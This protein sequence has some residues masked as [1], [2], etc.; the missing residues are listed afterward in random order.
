[1]EWSVF[2]YFI[3]F[4]YYFLF[5]SFIIIIIIFGPSS[6]VYQYLTITDHKPRFFA[7]R[8][9]LAVPANE[10]SLFLG[11]LLFLCL[12]LRQQSQCDCQICMYCILRYPF[13]YLSVT[14]FTPP[15]NRGGVLFL[16]Q[17]V[18]L[19]VCV[20]LSVCLSVRLLTKC[21]L[22]CYADFDAVFAK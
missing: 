4:C 9:P 16:L 7:H 10:E 8:Y 14:V 13:K 12:L 17:F 21:R 22:N 19:C 11:S 3:L 5:D 6:C 1:M 15:W 2:F 20:C 18:C